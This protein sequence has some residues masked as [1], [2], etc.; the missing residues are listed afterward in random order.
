[1]IHAAL[2]AAEGMQRYVKGTRQRLLEANVPEECVDYVMR[3][4][5]PVAQDTCTWLSFSPNLTA[6]EAAQKT[7]DHMTAQNTELLNKLLMAFIE[8]WHAR[9]AADLD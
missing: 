1:M 3:R 2:A 7:M 9:Q 6:R 4:V 5:E 8:I